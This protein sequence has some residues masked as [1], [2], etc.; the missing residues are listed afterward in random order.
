MIEDIEKYKAGYAI[1]I[2][3]RKTFMIAD[4]LGAIT[5]EILQSKKSKFGCNVFPYIQHLTKE[6]DSLY[7]LETDNRLNIGVSNI[8][9]DIKDPK[10]LSL[11]DGIEGYKTTII[12]NIMPSF[13]IGYIQRIGYI[14]R[15]IVKDKEIISNFV[16]ST[17]GKGF[18]DVNDV[19]LQ[20]SKRIPIG[21]SIA[22]QGIEN[23]HNVIINIIKKNNLD[24]IFVSVDFQLYYSPMIQTSKQIEFDSFIQT[25]ENY[26]KG[27]VLNYLNNSY[28]DFNE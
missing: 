1:G 23:Y 5:D 26:I 15:Y 24:E 19:N 21:L 11:E 12:D 18:S 22:K 14:K 16:K 4:N 28:G 27:T 10:K 8:V 2:R 9:L 13:S 3:Y 7:D 20:F 17:V 25:A 6:E